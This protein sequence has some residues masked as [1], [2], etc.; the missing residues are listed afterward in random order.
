MYYSRIYLETQ[1]YNDM[2]SYEPVYHILWLN[3]RLLY[4]GAMKSLSGPAH[5]IM[6]HSF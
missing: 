6:Q 4:S 2:H 3:I 1:Y 5:Y